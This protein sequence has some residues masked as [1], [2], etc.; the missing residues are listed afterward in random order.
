MSKNRR[1][2]L[3]GGAGALMVACGGGGET[4]KEASQK[5]PE[6][7]VA[8]TKVDPATAAK[9]SGKVMYSGPKP[10]RK[11][12]DMSSEETECKRSHKGPVQSEEVILNKDGSLANVFVYVSSG[13]EGKKFE[14][15]KAPVKIDQR[16]CM[17]APHV[18]GV[19]TSQPLLVSNSDPVTHNVHPIPEKNREWNQGQPPGAPEIERTFRVE[20]IMIPVKCN[21]HSWM[22]S[23]ICVVA[24]PYFA[25][26][27]EGGT[28][29][30]AGLPPGE[31][32]ITAWHEKFGKQEAK[33]T[34]A[35]SGAG[36]AE[37][38]FKG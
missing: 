13:L 16:G 6:T 24:H 9:V 14:P 34:L 27:G 18:V 38:T 35:P 30:L 19:M 23:Y 7:A 4:G 3:V 25:V 1:Q 11:V 26:T 28:F 37:F 17:F 2:F 20:E 21:V 29:E 31:Y 22:R 12:I 5:A 36:T 15:A 32:T 33:V 10:V 8:Y